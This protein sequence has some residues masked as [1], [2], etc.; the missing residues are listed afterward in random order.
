MWALGETGHRANLREC[1]LMTQSRHF[2]AGPT[3]NSITAGFRFIV[4]REN[5]HLRPTAFPSRENDYVRTIFIR[6]PAQHHRSRLP[7]GGRR[8][9]LSL[10]TG[11]LGVLTACWVRAERD[12]GNWSNV[13]SYD[14]ARIFAGWRGILGGPCRG[15]R[16]PRRFSARRFFNIRNLDQEKSRDQLRFRRDGNA[17][18]SRARDGRGGCR[19]PYHA[20]GDV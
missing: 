15:Q 13:A 12:D 17:G 3:F 16:I 8:R 9:R 7:C 6:Y 18:D 5:L 10:G 2:D 4:A 1:P 19:R 14:T 20:R 11:P